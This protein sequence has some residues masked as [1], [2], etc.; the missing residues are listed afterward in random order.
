M[1][2]KILSV[3]NLEWIDSDHSGIDMTLDLE[4]VGEIPFTA[5]PDDIEPHGRQLFAD[6]VAGE[7]GPIKERGL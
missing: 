6:A 5:R 3:T 4:G 7:F 1:L 2:K